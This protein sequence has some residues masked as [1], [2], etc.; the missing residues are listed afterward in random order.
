MPVLPGSGP[1]APVPVLVPVPVPDVVAR[2]AA[3]GVRL[4][5]LMVALELWREKK[6]EPSFLVLEWMW[7]VVWV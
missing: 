5:L 3:A 4:V 6:R 2:G 7:K 1:D